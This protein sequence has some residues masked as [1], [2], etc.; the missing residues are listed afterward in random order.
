M[1]YKIKNNRWSI[2]NCREKYSISWIIYNLY[3][4]Y[5]S[6]KL[7]KIKINYFSDWLKYFH[8]KSVNA[9]IIMKQKDISKK[10]MEIE[11][12]EYKYPINKYSILLN[13]W[14]QKSIDL[15]DQS[16]YKIKEFTKLYNYIGFLIIFGIDEDFSIHADPNIFVNLFNLDL[17]NTLNIKPNIKLVNQISVIGDIQFDSYGCNKIEYVIDHNNS[18]LRCKLNNNNINM[19]SLNI[20]L[21]K[22]Q[23]GTEYWSQ[24][25]IN[26]FPAYT[27]L[28][29]KPN[30]DGLN[31]HGTE[32]FG[33][34]KKSL[35]LYDFFYFLNSFIP[36]WVGIGS[37][38]GGK[39]LP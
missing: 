5:A 34:Y 8:H 21:S 19:D 9:L 3:D 10:I 39:W 17:T 31:I 26:I 25:L 14:F 33:G 29:I 24:L 38:P 7:D 37:L 6:T 1:C 32:L 20:Y 36:G 35:Q 12:G 22:I 18:Q 11:R 28:Y 23:I 30:G 2:W 16:K 27:I 13:I 15:F 4:S